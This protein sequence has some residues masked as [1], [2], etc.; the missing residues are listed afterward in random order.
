MYNFVT[1]IECIQKYLK[2][3]KIIK[4]ALVLYYNIISYYIEYHKYINEYY[5]LGIRF[6]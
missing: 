1:N 3:I 6:R 4:C 2:E 5:L